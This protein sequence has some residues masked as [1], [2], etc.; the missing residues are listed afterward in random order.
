[1]PRIALSSGLSRT[2]IAANLLDGDFPAD[3]PNRKWVGN[4]SSIWTAG[5]WLYLAVVIALFSRRVIGWAVSDRIKKDLAIRI[6]MV[7]VPLVFEAR[8][9]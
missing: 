7:S 1:M 9:A 5:D 3:R 8:V 4:I 6:W 2:R